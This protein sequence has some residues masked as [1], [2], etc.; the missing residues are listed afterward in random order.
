MLFTNDKDLHGHFNETLP[1]GRSHNVV[2]NEEAKYGVAVGVQPRNEYCKGGLHFFSLDDPAKPKALGCNGDDGYVHDVCVPVHA[3]S[4][5][6]ANLRAG[7]MLDLPW[8]RHQVPGPR[9]L[10]RIQ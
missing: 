10:L 1:I 4:P 6:D 5:K 8:P 9:Y 2:I 7:S 3:D